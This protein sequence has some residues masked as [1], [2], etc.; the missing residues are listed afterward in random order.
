M[1]RSQKYTQRELLEHIIELCD[2][3]R[4]EIG[5]KSLVEFRADRNLSDATAYRLQAIGEACTKLDDEIKKDYDLPW[6]EIIG[7]RQILSHDYLAISKE[8]IFVTARTNLNELYAACRAAI[9]KE[10]GD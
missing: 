8:I 10:S 4:E 6:K 5:S 3:I 7:M 1:A 2:T 9:A